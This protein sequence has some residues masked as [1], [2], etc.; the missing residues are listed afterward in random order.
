MRKKTIKSTLA[1]F[2]LSGAV[3]F[4]AGFANAQ[5]SFSVQVNDEEVR[6]VDQQPFIDENN[7]TLVPVRFVS[8]AL[9][10]RVD[11]NGDKGDQGQV[12]I[13]RDD[14]QLIIE[15]GESHFY[16][17]QEK[18]AIDTEAKITNQNRTVLPVRALS[19]ALGADVSWED[20]TVSIEDTSLATEDIETKEDDTTRDNMEESVEGQETEIGAK[21]EKVTQVNE[22]ITSHGYDALEEDAVEKLIKQSEQ[23]D[24]DLSLLLGLMRVESTFN[25]ENVGSASGALGLFQIMP[26]TASNLASQH[27]WEYEREK[28]FDAQYNIKLGTTY[29]HQLMEKYDGNVHKALSGYNRGT[30]GLQNYMDVHGTP[31][32]D[33]SQMVLDK[34]DKYGQNLN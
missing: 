10:A 2:A 32:S 6:F 31:V 28:L 5:D 24:L 13:K 11:W 17:D 15:I 4:N 3:L 1:I 33:F 7:R 18:V 30:V 34:A 8:E 20:D 22:A 19:E 21:S 16:H 29:L 9:G 27:G 25:P 23:L 12:H 26:G 14:T